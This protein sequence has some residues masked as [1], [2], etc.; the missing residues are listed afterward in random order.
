MSLP[1]PSETQTERRG[2][3]VEG[4]ALFSVLVGMILPQARGKS[5]KQV[6]PWLG[7]RNLTHGEGKH[8]EDG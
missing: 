2:G 7:W 6:V 5:R 3:R 1:E 4:P 8:R